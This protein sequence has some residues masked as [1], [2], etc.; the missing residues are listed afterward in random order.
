[1]N[2]ILFF[3]F[4]FTQFYVKKSSIRPGALDDGRYSFLAACFGWKENFFS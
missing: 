3:A 2:D 1:L 4:Y